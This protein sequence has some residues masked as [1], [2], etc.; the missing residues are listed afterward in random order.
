MISHDMLWYDMSKALFGGF[1]FFNNISMLQ[2]K[3]GLLSLSFNILRIRTLD[4]Q[5]KIPVDIDIVGT[6]AALGNFIHALSFQENPPFLFTSRLQ[7][8]A[9]RG[10]RSGYR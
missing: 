5:A 7:R 8:G 9:G 1:V 10:H 2:Y 4:L 3:K 6:Y